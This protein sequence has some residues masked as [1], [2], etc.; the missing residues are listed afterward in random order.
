MSDFLI[1]IVQFFCIFSF[2][3]F[4]IFTYVPQRNKNKSKYFFSKESIEK[5]I[6]LGSY[7]IFVFLHLFYFNVLILNRTLFL[8]GFIISITALI[9]ARFQ[10][11]EVWNPITSHE[12]SQ[13]IIISGIFNLH[14]HPIYFARILFGI[15]ICLMFN[16]LSL[17]LMPLYWTYLKNRIE[18]EE[19][20]LLKVNGREYYKYQKNVSKFGF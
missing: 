7:Y 11:R 18:V 10:L 17:F 20:Y 6:I 4:L 19:K 5:T 9:I 12:N 8:I 16:L 14:R 13:K 1:Q 3:I 15:S 2:I